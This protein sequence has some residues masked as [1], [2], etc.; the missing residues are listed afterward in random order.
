MRNKERQMKALEEFYVVLRGKKKVLKERM[1]RRNL[2][3][4]APL[5]LTDFP[6]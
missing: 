1:E 2:W 3:Q 6:C 4:S 5:I